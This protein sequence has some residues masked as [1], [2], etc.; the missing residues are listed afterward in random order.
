MARVAV[1]PQREAVEVVLCRRR[2]VYEV[3]YCAVA[4]ATLAAW[5]W[6]WPGRLSVGVCILSAWAMEAC[7]CLRVAVGFPSV[8]RNALMRWSRAGR[9]S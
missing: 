6:W 9:W 7:G 5:A 1:L 3:E 4:V 8:G 2:G